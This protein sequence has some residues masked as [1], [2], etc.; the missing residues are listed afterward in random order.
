MWILEWNT[1]WLHILLVDDWTKVRSIFFVILKN[2]VIQMISFGGIKKHIHGYVSLKQ[3]VSCD[4]VPG[5]CL[6]LDWSP[7]CMPRD[8]GTVRGRGHQ[9]CMQH[10][11]AVRRQ[12]RSHGRAGTGTTASKRHRHQEPS[13]SVSRSPNLC[14]PGAIATDTST[15]GLVQLITFWPI[16]RPQRMKS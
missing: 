14:E 9:P 7:I 5:H 2:V 16:R 1:L 4:H 12:W 3:V 11:I 8:M 6:P 13:G 15:L 10:Q